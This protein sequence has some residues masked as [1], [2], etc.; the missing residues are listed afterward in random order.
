MTSIADCDESTKW[1]QEHP[2]EVR[3]EILKTHYDSLKPKIKDQL[4]A[5]PAPVQM[6]FMMSELPSL[7]VAD[8]DA[9]FV[10]LQ[11]RLHKYINDDYWKRL[12]RKCEHV[13][14]T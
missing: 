6:A 2:T 7:K 3:W 8:T 9:E 14:E 10:E 11:N 12:G 5:S 4:R 13:K 1:M